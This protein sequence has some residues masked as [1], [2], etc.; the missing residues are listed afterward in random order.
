MLQCRGKV[1]PPFDAS[2]SLIVLNQLPPSGVI[3]EECFVTYIYKAKYMY[4]KHGKEYTIQSLPCPRIQ[5]IEYVSETLK[6][7]GS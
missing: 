5:Y 7:S 1:L 6:I 3:T 4:T 2:I